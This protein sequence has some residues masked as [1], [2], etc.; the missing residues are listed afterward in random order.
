MEKIC[1]KEEGEEDVDEK[2]G[3]TLIQYNII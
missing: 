2:Y 3:I 1:R